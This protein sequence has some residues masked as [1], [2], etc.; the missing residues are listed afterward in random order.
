V[1]IL[2]KPLIKGK[3]LTT[4]RIHFLKTVHWWQGFHQI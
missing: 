4:S 3:D 1:Y 2:W